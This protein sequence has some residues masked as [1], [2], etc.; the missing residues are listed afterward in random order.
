MEQ[1]SVD[2]NAVTQLLAA[3]IADLE[4]KLAVTSVQLQ[5]SQNQLEKL[6]SSNVSEPSSD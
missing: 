6:R 4:L 1:T 3:K 2:A 5:E